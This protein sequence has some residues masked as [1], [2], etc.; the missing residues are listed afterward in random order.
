MKLYPGFKF[1]F[2]KCNLYRYI[3]NLLLKRDDDLSSVVIADFG[4]AKRCR[5][6]SGGSASLPHAKGVDDSAVG[7]G[8]NTS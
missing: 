5:E 7:L 3:E 8:Q 6:K 2:F 1:C 4:L